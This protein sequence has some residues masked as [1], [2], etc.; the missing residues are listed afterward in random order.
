MNPVG[1]SSEVSKSKTVAA[2]VVR[3]SDYESDPKP[4]EAPT[5]NT[6]E[7]AAL[8]LRI[9]R[10]APPEGLRAGE[11][12]GKALRVHDKAKWQSLRKARTL[13]SEQFGIEITVDGHHR[14]RL[15]DPNAS[16][17]LVDPTSDDVTAVVMAT[18]LLAPIV[19]EGLRQ[20]LERLVAD[21]DQAYRQRNKKRSPKVP[22][23][24]AV[25]STFSSG[26]V[27][28]PKIL[29]DLALAVG[30]HPVKINYDKPWE[31]TSKRYVVEPWQLRVHDGGFYL[32]GFSR[33][34]KEPRNFRVV[35]IRSCTVQTEDRLREPIP[36]TD[37][38]WTESPAY[39]LD[40]D[41]PDTAVIRIKGAY[42]RWVAAER[43]HPE[44]K[45]TWVTKGELLERRLPYLSCRE[46]ARRV[47]TLGDALVS[48]EPAE[49]AKEVAGHASRMVK[50]LG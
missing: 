28:N 43:W 10:D 49:L 1:K 24:A 21:I 31:N 46:L 34:A 7:L 3:R 50:R 36:P 20:H 45:D 38:L 25:A 32:R 19:D 4:R 6:L 27:C 47:L 26:Q 41:R 15:E 44:Q 17:P 30:R 13:L 8:W 33:H 23:R 14:Y 11:I 12:E 29:A 39:G 42:A 18:S 22:K 5:Q 48:V 40:E 2:R 37:K 35:Q 9:L 16:L